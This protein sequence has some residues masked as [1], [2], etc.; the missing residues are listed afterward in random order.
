G[1]LA[2]AVVRQLYNLSQEDSLDIISG[3][4]SV[5]HDRVQ[6]LLE[7]LSSQPRPAQV[8]GE[9]HA[10]VTTLASELSQH[11]KGVQKVAFKADKRDPEFMFYDGLS[12]QMSAS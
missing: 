7:F 11:V 3:D 4:L 8:L 5:Q 10:V 12:F 1:L 9:D 6:S 2:D